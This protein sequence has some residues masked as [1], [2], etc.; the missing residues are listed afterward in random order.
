MPI[1]TPAYP[2]QNSTYNV[3]NSTLYQMKL[4][5]ARSLTISN[6]ILTKTKTWQDFFEKRDFFSEFKIF[7]QIQIW[8]ENDDQ[9]RTWYL[10]FCFLIF[11]F[12]YIFVYY[13]L[14]IIPNF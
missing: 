5:F 9:M 6:Q 13:Y 12:V 4:E 14:I 8:A 2:A 1:I 11:L 7:V 10:L 3:S